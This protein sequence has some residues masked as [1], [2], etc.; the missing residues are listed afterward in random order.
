MGSPVSG[1]RHPAR[2]LPVAPRWFAVCSLFFSTWM[3]V[4]TARVNPRNA[5]SGSA[6]STEGERVLGDAGAA[7]CAQSV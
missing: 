3:G 4:L 2:P 6:P 5:E 7:P 1:F